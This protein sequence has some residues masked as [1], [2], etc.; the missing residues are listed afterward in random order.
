[1]ETPTRSDA[2]ARRVLV[3]GASGQDGR[4]L[5]EALVAEGSLVFGLIAPGHDNTALG[6]PVGGVHFLAGDLRD[7]DSLR[8]ALDQARPDE[9]YNLAAITFVPSSWQTPGAIFDVNTLGVARLLAAIRDCG[10]PI[11]VCQ[12]STSEIF[13]AGSRLPQDETTALRPANPYGVTKAEAHL[14]IARARDQHGLFACSA[15]LFNH[16]SPLRPAH[17]VTRKITQGAARIARGL[18]RELVLGDLDATRDWGYAPEYMEAL[19]LMLGGA[20]ARDYVVATGR[21]ATVREFAALAF[22]HLGLDW[23]RYVRSDSALQR[24]SDGAVR[25]GNPARIEREL[26]WKARTSLEQLVA[27]MVDADLSRLDAV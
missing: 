27:T 20:R 11:R 2:W 10:A 6:P 26:G 18:D 24:S 7:A 16:E 22:A 14:L 9:I 15:I 4:Y 17:F 23:R 19:R 25:V 8:R 3:T 21:S 13:G 5:C 1:M 12:A